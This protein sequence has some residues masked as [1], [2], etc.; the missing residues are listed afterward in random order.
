MFEDNRLTH[1]ENEVRRLKRL[2]L[3]L[4]IVLLLI[5]SMAAASAVPPTVFQWKNDVEIGG[6]L[7]VGDKDILVELKNTNDQAKTIQDQVQ[8]LATKR[9]PAIEEWQKTKTMELSQLDLPAVKKT[10][11][12]L[13]RIEV[14]RI[15]LG[16]RAPR[17]RHEHD[18]NLPDNTLGVCVRV[19]EE[20]KIADAKVSTL[21]VM[22]EQRPGQPKR[23]KVLFEHNWPAAI[24]CHADV[25]RIYRP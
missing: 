13:P 20:N 24:I 22:M 23:C 7:K 19:N 14:S 11:E 12:T 3:C 9:L 15:D 21:G 5:L 8:E 18:F 10:V 17:A 6:T 25:I 2:S 16:A 1:L 4:S